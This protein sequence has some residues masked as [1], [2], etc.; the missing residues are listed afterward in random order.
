MLDRETQDALTLGSTSFSAKANAYS[1]YSNFPVGAA[2]L[3]SDGTIVKGASI[4]NASYSETICAER[5]AVVKAVSEGIRS[6]AALAVVSNIPHISPCGLCRQVIVEFCAPEMPVLLV[7]GDYLTSTGELKETTV[8]EL[9]PE[10]D[11]Y[12]GLQ[13]ASDFK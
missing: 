5:T 3:C 2:L 4:D 9:F 10:H 8:G 7:T 1:P 11:N 6:F 13:V 12:L